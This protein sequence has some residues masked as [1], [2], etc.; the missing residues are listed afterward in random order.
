MDE[1]CKADEGKLSND[2]CIPFQ[3]CTYACHTNFY[4]GSYFL[5]FVFSIFVEMID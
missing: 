1:D 5:C 3:V 2:S 4:F